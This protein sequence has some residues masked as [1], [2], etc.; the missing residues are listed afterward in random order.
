MASVRLSDDDIHGLKAC[1]VDEPAFSP[2][3]VHR[4]GGIETPLS[5]SLGG[6]GMVGSKLVGANSEKFFASWHLVLLACWY[7][8]LRRLGCLTGLLSAARAL[9]RSAAGNWETSAVHRG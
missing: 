7:C 1:H 4:V 3:Q 5:P 6:R 8:V 2:R 9:G